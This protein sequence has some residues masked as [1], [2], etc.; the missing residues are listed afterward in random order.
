MAEEMLG[1]KPTVLY[2]R[3]NASRFWSYYHLLISKCTYLT[4]SPINWSQETKNMYTVFLSAPQVGII[5]NLYVFID[6][7]VYRENFSSRSVEGVTMCNKW[8]R[9][10]ELIPQ[11][12]IFA[13]SPL[14][15]ILSP[16]PTYPP[17]PCRSPKKGFVRKQHQVRKCHWPQIPCLQAVP[18]VASL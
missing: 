6:R 9:G 11:F 14:P 17:P 2:K 12:S 7:Y 13:L 1:N 18:P 8:E 4:S 3:G 15:F 5:Y 16:I 10:R